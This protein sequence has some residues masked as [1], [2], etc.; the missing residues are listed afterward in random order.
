MV[1]TSKQ[2]KRQN[3]SARL[4][5]YFTA[6][7]PELRLNLLTITMILKEVMMTAL[8]SGNEAGCRKA[9]CDTVRLRLRLNDFEIVE[10]KFDSPVN[11]VLGYFGRGTSTTYQGMTAE[12]K[13]LNHYKPRLLLINGQQHG[14]RS[15]YLQIDVSLPKLLYGNNLQ[16]VCNQDF[17][18][19]V[20]KLK[21]VLLEMG[22]KV[23][24]NVLANA[25]IVRY[26]SCK[27]IILPKGVATQYIVSNVAKINFGARSGNGHTDYLNGGH[28]ARFHYND[29]EIA[30]Y[31]KIADIRQMQFSPKRCID[32]ESHRDFQNIDIEKLGNLQVLRL[33]V[34]LNNSKVLRRKLAK[35]GIFF[36]EGYTIT[37]RDVFKSEIAR[38]LNVH[39]WRKIYEAGRQIYFLQDGS[40]SMLLN[41]GDAKLLKKFEFIGMAKVIDDCGA[42]YVKRLIGKNATALKLFNLVKSYE[43][44]N[45]TLM[46]IFG[47]IGKKLVANDVIVLPSEESSPQEHSEESL[48]T[49][50]STQ[51]VLENLKSENNIRN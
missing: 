34:R 6:C 7:R 37:F 14:G 41:L 1:Q 18:P 23:S 3:S 44:D 22:I 40:E 50:E 31:D 19:S 46:K 30:V 51:N 47:G 25:P 29:Y 35:V 39:F 2:V 20:L 13:R 12:D 43:P 27:N 17:K 11:K 16:E 32:E 36:E 38:K 9:I 10:D 26:H 21:D 4:S 28:C 45:K 5:L 48:L 15:I 42:P 24:P 33:E 8:L 49:Q